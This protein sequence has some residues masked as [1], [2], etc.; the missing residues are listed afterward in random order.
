MED[1]PPRGEDP[2]DFD[3]G[4]RPSLPRR[5]RAPESGRFNRWR[6]RLYGEDEE[7][8]PLGPDEDPLDTGEARRLATER[9]ERFDTGE[10]RRVRAQR[11]RRA[12]LPAKFRRRQLIALLSL[13]LLLAL[14]AY[15]IF[16]RGDDEAGSGEESIP[17]KR[18][19]GQA[20][21]GP[22]PAAG[23]DK[24]LV[25]RV[26]KGQVG[27]VIV[28][29]ESEAVAQRDIARLQAAAERGGNPPLLVMVDQE[30]G[31]VKL[32]PGPPDLGPEEIA[33]EGTDTA[34][35]EGANTGEYL[36]TLGINLNLAPVVDVAHRQTEETI[37]SRTYSDDPAEVG[38][39]GAAFIRGQQ[40]QGVAAT[41]KHYPGLGLATQ[42]T[43]FAPVAVTGTDEDLT[44][45]LEPFA[46]AIDAG[47][48]LVMVSTASFESSAEQPAVFSAN[49]IRKQ[50]RTTMG[51][52]GLVITD[53]LE[54]PAITVGPGSAALQMLR[55]GADLALFAQTEG[56][57]EKALRAIVKALRDG[58][59]DRAALEQVYDGVVALKQ[60]LAA[61]GPVSTPPASSDQEEEEQSSDEAPA[62]GL[63]TSG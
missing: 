22:L 18:L 60:R 53:D 26:E 49:V 54:T 37:L 32:L 17:L 57:S 15:L 12:D 35:S 51:F 48:D 30:G 50:L 58:R 20:L 14:G 19:A 27:G 9:G 2:F 1:W 4:E 59:L 38:E 44:A 47:V 16:L 43:D 8:G 40:A 13:G 3:T 36:A 45:D 23:A 6:Q 29:T 11:R 10:Y 25:K 31:F 55:A 46:A 28:R 41:A 5:G 63:P 34:E 7:E 62:V 52:Q 56:A 42:N 24:G 39:L 33:A 61:G 21:I